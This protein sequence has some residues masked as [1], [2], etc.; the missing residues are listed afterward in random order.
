MRGADPPASSNPIPVP[1]ERQVGPV[2][3]GMKVQEFQ[4]TVKSTEQ[5]GPGL[6]LLENER[7]FEV[8]RGGLPEGMRSMG[9][10][11]LDDQLYRITV[12]FREGYFDEARWNETIKK[13]MEQYGKAPIQ[14][15]RLKAR[16]TDLIQW[17]DDRTRFLIQREHRM[18]LESEKRV[19]R[20]TVMMVLLDR[21]LWE[22]RE[23]SEISIF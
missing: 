20:F 11:F 12:D 17:D 3:L 6:G 1:I 19:I 23:A 15:P 16:P 8:D 21:A 5:V 14:S 22:K 10:R 2:R 4:E 7:S 18:R 9:C 13:H